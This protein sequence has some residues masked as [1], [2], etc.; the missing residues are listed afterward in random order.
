VEYASRRTLPFRMGMVGAQIIA[1]NEDGSFNSPEKPALKGTYLCFWGTGQG[2]VE[3]SDGYL[4]PVLPVK[5][6]VGGIEVSVSFAGLIDTGV[7]QVNVKSP[8]MHNRRMPW[9][10]CLRLGPQ[11]A[12]KLPPWRSVKRKPA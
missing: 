1:S 2:L 6:S 8:R 12:E 10:F 11:A 3:F 5:A 7:M 4:R 9:T